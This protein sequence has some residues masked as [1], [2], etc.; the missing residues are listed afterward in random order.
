MAYLLPGAIMFFCV[1]VKANSSEHVYLT[2]EKINPAAT[3]GERMLDDIRSGQFQRA[4]RS[5]VDGRF[6]QGKGDRKI[7]CQTRAR[8]LSLFAL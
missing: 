1:L 2:V 7:C 4:E 8:T 5:Q 3:Q 6:I